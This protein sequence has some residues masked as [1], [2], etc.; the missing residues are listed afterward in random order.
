MARMIKHI[1]YNYSKNNR[2]TNI[3]LDVD[4][5]RFERQYQEAQYILD[6][7]IMTQMQPFMPMQTGIFINVTKE[8]SASLAGT[9]TVVAAAPPFGRFLYEGKVMVDEVTG[10]PWA[11]KGAKKVAIDKDLVYSKNAHPEVTDH[12]F[13]KAEKRYGNNWI[14]MTKRTAG[15]G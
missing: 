3:E 8:M 12:W 6:S 4:L 2:I 9:G 5:S 10:S 15:G 11:R 1:V 7:M 14:K 13:D